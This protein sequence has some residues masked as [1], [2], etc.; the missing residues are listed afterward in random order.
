MG[1]ISKAIKQSVT[2]AVENFLVFGCNKKIVPS[3]TLLKRKGNDQKEFDVS[4]PFDFPANLTLQAAESQLSD[5]II[6]DM[7]DEIFNHIF[8]DW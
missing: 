3:I 1:I 7:T 2:K 6:R 8:S 5:Q 4:H